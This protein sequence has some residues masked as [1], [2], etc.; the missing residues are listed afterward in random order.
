MMG[1]H[2][3]KMGFEGRLALERGVAN[4]TAG[5]VV[6]AVRVLSGGSR[7]KGRK[8]GGRE[9]RYVDRG[10]GQV[11]GP[12]LGEV[13]ADTVADVLAFMLVPAVLLEL[14]TGPETIAAVRTRNRLAVR[15]ILADTL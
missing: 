5:G 11:A 8:G 7:T 15:T 9:G 14:A 12:Y 13:L 6:L 4:L 1:V 3:Q 10:G 2:C